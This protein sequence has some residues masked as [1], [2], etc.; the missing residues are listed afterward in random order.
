MSKT[1]DRNNKGQ[2]VRGNKAGRVRPSRAIELNYLRT[3]SDVI[4][5]DDWRGI[6][7]KAVQDAKSGN[8]KAREWK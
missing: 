5:V 7:D 4:T 1:T 3:L 2:F 8:A 6:C